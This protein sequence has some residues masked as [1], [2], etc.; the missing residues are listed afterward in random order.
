[1]RKQAD[2]CWMHHAWLTALWDTCSNTY[3]SVIKQKS[4]SFGWRTH[5]HHSE[6]CNP[7]VLHRPPSPPLCSSE[8]AAFQN[9]FPTEGSY[10]SI[11]KNLRK[12]YDWVKEGKKISEFQSFSFLLASSPCVY[13]PVLLCWWAVVLF[14]VFFFLDLHF[15]STRTYTKHM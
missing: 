6:S 10:Q 1:M 13:S 15:G 8:S 12:Y 11:M 9:P 3:Y 4:L 7:K 14:N 5:L 2:Q